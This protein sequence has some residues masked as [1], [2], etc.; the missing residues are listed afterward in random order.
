MNKT[1]GFHLM[2]NN[3]SEFSVDTEINAIYRLNKFLI[4]NNVHF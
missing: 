1:P 2:L 4:S 3:N